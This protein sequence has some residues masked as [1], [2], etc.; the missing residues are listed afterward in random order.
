[1]RDDGVPGSDNLNLAETIPDD[2]ATRLRIAAEIVRAMR[3]I[4]YEC[5]LVHETPQ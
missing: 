4:G 3:E 5:E 2:E 1:M